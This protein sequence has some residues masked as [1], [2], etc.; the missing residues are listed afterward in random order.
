MPSS[1]SS[2]NNKNRRRTMKTKT[3]FKTVALA[4]LMPAMLLTSACSN[5]DDIANTSNIT[6]KG[7]ALPVTVNVTRGDG[8]TTRATFDGS[9]LNFSD[10]DKLFVNGYASGT[11]G[12]FA[13][14]LT[15]VSAGTF[16]GTIYTE[17]LY[18][19][20]ADALLAEAGMARAT[21]LPAG[22]SSYGYL[23]ITIQNGYDDYL[24]PDY[25]KAFTTSTA[26]K[27]AK[28][29][30]V[31][32]F[33]LETTTYS[34]G[35]A[36]S[37]ANVILNFTITG[38][39]ASTEVTASFTD[40]YSNVI[41]GNVT[42]DGSG[43]ATFAIG[44]AG[45]T[46]LQYCSLTVGGNAITLT[47]SDKYLTEGKIYNIT[48]GT[49]TTVDLSTKDANYT[50]QNGETLTG[51]LGANVKISI[52]DGATVILNNVS[53]NAD[54]TWKSSNYAGITCEGDATII[55]S[56]T[57][58]VRGF[59]GYYP[60]LQAGPAGTTLT[61]KGTGSLTALYAN[62]NYPGG[63][64]I[65][66]A[67]LVACGNIVIEGGNIT[68][69]G[70]YAGIGGAYGYSGEEGTCGDITI[71]GGTVT[72]TALSYGAGIG[73][74]RGEFGSCGNITISG[75]TVTAIAT[76]KNTVAAAIGAGSESSTCTSVTIGT[77]ITSLTMTNGH[78]SATGIVS[79]F[80]N[81]TAVYANTTPITTM[82]S[83]SVT[84]P[85]ITMGMGMAGFATLYDG[86]AKTWTVS[87]P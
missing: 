37:P 3:I 8:G 55:L 61:I 36:L 21:L 19:G 18:A 63:S 58:T 68:A 65:G 38:L 75:G 4:M 62:V 42:T 81:A 57:N 52:A 67:R 50:A 74:G 32:Q 16:S 72:A 25:T 64:G 27:T 12:S 47:S 5:Q 15:M 66:A 79:D 10:G 73:A 43:N 33:S 28:A 22:Y 17:N 56:G 31:E 78:K 71:T 87:K 46:N 41:S 44:V 35:F 51:T 60:G 70:G 2:I 82:L 54:G 26:L 20:N 30:A 59:S 86:D 23:P 84:D 40:E 14:T 69:T 6:S 77:G 24:K 11:A 13:G 48:R 1:H 29:I 49:G 45:N 76:A 80:I 39:A 7:Y 34:S 53:I 85:T 9:K 83:T